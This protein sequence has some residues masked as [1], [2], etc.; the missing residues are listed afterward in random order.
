M[1]SNSPETIALIEA[2][3]EYRPLFARH[4]IPLIYC[5]SRHEFSAAVEARGQS[6]RSIITRGTIDISAS[7]MRCL[8]A[9][10][11]ICALGSGVETIDLDAASAHAVSVVANVGVNASTVA[12]HAM[13]LLLAVVREIPAADSALRRGEWTRHL[14]P[15]VA[16][17]RLGVV[18]LG[19]VGMEVARRAA[20]GF[21]MSVSYHNRGPRPDAEDYRYVDSASQ[22][23]R[24]SDFLLVS[25]PATPDTHHIVNRQV[26][27][28]L[29][30][31]G[32]LVNVARGEL[33]DTGALVESLRAGR[34]AGAALD[35][36][37]SEPA[38]PESLRTLGNVV[39]TSHYA[40]RSPESTRAAVDRAVGNLRQHHAARAAE[41]QGE[42]VSRHGSR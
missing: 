17:K 15:A 9:L 37:E 14:P 2:A 10:E 16:G 24:E 26:L 42:Q 11:I 31:K 6:I 25:A 29:G 28:E 35:V 4:D 27:G 12:D 19:A 13:G 22:L 30:A 41:G 34:L 8:P 23:A 36:F 21:G 1:S 39:L 18:G 7:D 32:Y 38:V 3:D 40:G 5:R 20:L 33:V